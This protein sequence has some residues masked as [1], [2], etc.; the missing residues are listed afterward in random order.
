MAD[1]SP[2]ARV[3]AA[4][5]F[6]D[7]DRIP[8]DFGSTIVTTIYYTA[9]D[10]LKRELGL[11]HETVMVAKLKRLAVPDAAILRRFDVDTRYLALG[12]YEGDQKELDEHSYLD[13]WGTTW[14]QAEDG[15][16]L[17]V[18][19]PFFNIK[20]PTAEDLGRCNWPDPDNP[21]H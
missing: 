13:E 19:G 8:I 7:T 5:N 10:D 1:M 21:G 3:L 11:D 4:L 15:H 14:K 20:K 2:R 9:Y 6:H 18:D 17:F 16:F 12:V